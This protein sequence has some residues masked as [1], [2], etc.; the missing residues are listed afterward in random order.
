MDSN[1]FNAVFWSFFITSSIGLIIGLV[2]IASKSKCSECSVCGCYIKRNI[3][4]ELEEEKMELEHRL[5]VR[6]EQKADV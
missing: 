3:E 5:P 6:E 1:I 4:A 2:K